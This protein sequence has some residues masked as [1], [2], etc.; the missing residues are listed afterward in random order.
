LRSTF[1]VGAKSTALAGVRARSLYAVVLL[2]PAVG[3]EPPVAACTRELS[4]QITPADTT[5][6]LGASFLPSLRLST[7]GGSEQLEDV[8]TWRS[9]DPTVAQVAPSDG[10]ITGTGVGTVHIVATGQR[11]GPLGGLAV[12]VYN[13]VNPTVDEARTEL[14]HYI[15]AVTRATAWRYGV[16]D[17]ARHTMDGL[18]IIAHPDSGG[19]IGV[20]HAYRGDGFDA[21]L[22][23]SSD[24]LNWTWRA[25]IAGSASQP[26]IRAADGGFIVAWETDGDNHLRLAF[27]DSWTHL[28]A[29]TPSRE[30]DAPRTLSRCA[31][32]TPNI[33][34]G[35]R[36][37]VDVGFHYWWNCDVDRQARGVTDW[38]SWSAAAQ[39]ALDTAILLHGV[40]G[41]IGD[42]DGM[43]MFR[44]HAFGLL[45]GR[46]AKDDWASWRVFLYDYETGTAEQLDI[47]TDMGSMSFGNPTIEHVRIG[48]RDALVVTLFLFGEGAASGEGGSLVYYRTYP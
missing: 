23:T 11:F 6:T 22:A 9:E 44:G 36:T 37:Q 21:H 10:R 8:I 30:F 12:F 18:K 48:G 25:R 31:E 19:F 29:G 17:D 16:H 26:T 4:V 41:N 13:P 32:G 14:R 5:I 42:R 38:T 28:L 33:Y 39:P 46:F 45:E 15:E 40:K 24:L 35:D 1:S 7:C 43:L 27:Y 2:A 20:Y 34:V 47:R 3:C